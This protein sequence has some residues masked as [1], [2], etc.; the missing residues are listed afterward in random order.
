MK[1]M[2]SIRL[3]ALLLFLCAVLLVLAG[4]VREVEKSPADLFDYDTEM[5]DENS[6]EITIVNASGYPAREFDVWWDGRQEEFDLLHSLGRNLEPD[7]VITLRIPRSESSTYAFSAWAD[8][9]DDYHGC[10]VSGGYQYIPEGGVIVLTP[11]DDYYD[12][13]IIFEAGTDVETA[14]ETVLSQYQAAREAELEAEEEKARKEAE[15]LTPEELDEAVKALGYD[16]LADMRTEENSSILFHDYDNEDKRQDHEGYYDLY[17]YWY[18]NG[19]RNSQ[20]YFAITDK[21]LRRYKFDPEQGDV[22]TDSVQIVNNSRES[23]ICTFYLEN[24]DIFT[25]ERKNSYENLSY[26][27]LTF[28]GGNTEYCENAEY[29]Y[30]ME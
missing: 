25:V 6:M 22:M 1:T 20:E 27:K 26:G 10:L 4:C 13:Q 15:G 3:G 5:T 7:E 11:D 8:D 24:G 18:P 9:G 14:K 23:T 30:S 17:G 29:Y 2:R 12:I 16:S 19:D 28:D 21:R